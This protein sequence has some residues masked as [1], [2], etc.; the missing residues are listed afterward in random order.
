MTTSNMRVNKTLVLGFLLLVLFLL[1]LSPMVAAESEHNGEEIYARLCATC[2][3]SSLAK[4]GVWYPSLRNIVSSNE[5]EALA[6]LID[7]GQFRRAGDSIAGSH[8]SHTIPFMPAWSWLTDRELSALVNFLIDEFGDGTVTLS[9]LEVRALRNPNEGPSLSPLEREA[10][11]N[12]YLSHC[13][14][15]HGT[16]RE[17]VV[18]PP[19]SQWPLQTFSMEQIRAT[20]H[21]GTLDGMPEWGVSVRLTAKQMTLLAR[22]L[23][24]PPLTETPTFDLAAMRTAWE[25]PQQ[26]FSE[27][28]LGADYLLTL[29]H[30]ARKVLFV[31]PAVQSVTAETQLEF[32]P[33]HVLQDRELWVLSREGW[34]TQIDPATKT[35][36]AQARAGYEPAMMAMIRQKDPNER[37]LAATTV[38]PPGVSFFEASSL[39]PIKRIDT[40]EPMGVFIGNEN[41]LAIL[42]RRNGCIYPLKVLDLAEQCL[43]GVPYPRYAAQV[44]NTSF[45]LV[46]GETGAVAVY[47]DRT[48]E[49]I[50]RANLDANVTPSQGTF[51]EHVE[52]GS[53]YLIASMTSPGITMIGVDPDRAPQ[54]AWQVIK[55]INAPTQGALFMASHTA[56]NLIVI[57][58]PV[59]DTH[60]GT[61]QVMDKTTFKFSELPIAAQ[62]KVQGTPRVLQPLFSHT[63]KEIWLTVWN[64]LDEQAA[65]VAVDA[66]SGEITSVIKASG[67]TTPIRSFWVKAN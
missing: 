5:P 28:K 31:N 29:L 38:S 40:E 19:L 2:H 34:I 62:T 43:T 57:D 47:D 17:G 59:S 9:E 66:E 37:I 61:V 64:R 56:S 18:G 45:H 54:H 23:Q 12:I 22:Y 20:L 10:A 35:V 16:T 44:P 24:E 6:Q 14:G 41:A 60:A 50:A 58:T 21:Y 7:H 30:D 46:V 25:P 8:P 39:E 15:C 3:E 67:L 13:A 53:V 4:Q 11:H 55:V 33:Y 48:Q 36:R 27:S 26:S 1:L 51:I 42:S 32:A 49:V 63:G 52:Y 65:L